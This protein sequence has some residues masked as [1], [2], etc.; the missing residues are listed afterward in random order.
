MIRTTARLTF[1]LHRFELAAVA[2]A[3]LVLAAA[4]LVVA[5]RLDAFGV[6]IS[7]FSSYLSNG[8][9]AATGA[10]PSH[11]EQLVR[12]FFAVNEEEAGKVMAAMAVLPPLAGLLL[13]IPL[14]SREV[15]SGTTAIAWSLTGSRWRWLL[16]RAAL[17]AVVL[18]VLVAIPAL[19]ADRLEVARQPWIVADRSFTDI[20]LRGIPVV[21]R[22]GVAFAVGLLVGAVIGRQLPALIV[23][24]VVLV[25]ILGAFA[26][27]RLSLERAE[28]VVTAQPTASSQSDSTSADPGALFLD[29]LLR[30]A[31]GALLRID[32]AAA[33]APTGTDPQQW[34][35]DHY[36]TVVLMTPGDRYPMIAWREAALLG[37]VALVLVGLSLV[38]VERRRPT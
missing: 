9:A 23:A 31:S 10:S 18:L 21:A 12:P 6:P 8:P 37:G 36:E 24:A 5:M 16:P 34:A 20:G 17:V 22:A 27:V 25:A 38:V 15:E 2:I 1:R 7:C 28:A 30:D 33:R 4:A 32:E 3:L 11:C 29:T 35:F 26:G 13:G 14:V 19:A